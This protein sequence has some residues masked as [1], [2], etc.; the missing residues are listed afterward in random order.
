MSLPLIC[1]TINGHTLDDM[2]EQAE[3]ATGE[4]ADI[5]EVRFDELYVERVEVKAENIEGEVEISHELVARSIDVI[6]VP[7]AIERLKAGIEKPVLFTCRPRHQGGHFPGTEGERIEVMSQAVSSGVSWVDLELDI[8]ESERAALI[9]QATEQGTKVVA[10]HHDMESTPKS[11]DILSF[12]AKN[13][14]HGDTVKLCYRTNG[15]GDALSLCEAAWELREDADLSLSL[16]GQGVGGDMPR[17]HAP[18][19]SQS[20]VYATL[21]TDFDLPDRGMINVRDLRIAWEMLGYSEA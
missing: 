2:V 11:A 13:R 6:D 14:Q 3:K 20:L 21:E 15:H 1:V 5:I 16:M 17:I 8:E 4:G 9:E 10:S 18:K 7:E 12:V 19:F